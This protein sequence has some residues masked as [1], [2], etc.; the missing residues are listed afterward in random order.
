MVVSSSLFVPTDPHNPPSINSGAFSNVYKAIDLRSGQKVAGE[1]QRWIHSYGLSLNLL[2]DRPV[3]VVRK[4]E[5]SASQVS[6][7]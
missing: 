2:S 6:I 5:L 1:Y 7:P 3:K 4:Y